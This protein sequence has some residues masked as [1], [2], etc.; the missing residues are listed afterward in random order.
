VKL[1][2]QV[3]EAESKLKKA[4]EAIQQL[5]DAAGEKPKPKPQPTEPPAASATADSAEQG[6]TTVGREKKPKAKYDK[7]KAKSDKATAKSDKSDKSDK[8]TAK[9]DKYDKATS[10]YDKAGKATSKSRD[11]KPKE[12]SADQVVDRENKNIALFKAQD[13]LIDNCISQLNPKILGEINTSLEYVINYRRTQTLKFDGDAHAVEQDGK[14]FEFSRSRFFE[15]RIF[16]DKLRSQLNNDVP[17]A[18]V[19]IFAGRDEGTYCLRFTKRRCD[20]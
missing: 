11:Y 12:P 6:W 5:A 16:Q 8:A 14:T 1:R 18:W 19:S 17:L 3:L 15:N 2:A 20:A 10:K 7:P 9:S 13:E 4:T